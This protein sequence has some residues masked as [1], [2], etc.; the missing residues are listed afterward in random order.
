MKSPM[1]LALVF[2]GKGKMK[3][4]PKMSGA[5]EPETQEEGGADLPELL[6][7]FEDAP[8]VGSR[9]AALAEFVRAVMETQ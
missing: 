7:E 1:N 5:D 6:A 2:P 9:S 4:K 3:M 8:D